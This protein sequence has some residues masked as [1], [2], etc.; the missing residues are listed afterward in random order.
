M[1]TIMSHIPTKYTLDQGN[2]TVEGL[3]RNEDENWTYTLVQNEENKFYS[4]EVR[5][6]TG[7]HVH[8]L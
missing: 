4:I 5:D 1:K 6:E 7:F 3:V 2:E 8:N